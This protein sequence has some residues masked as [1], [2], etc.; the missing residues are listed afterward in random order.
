MNAGSSSVR[1]DEVR[2]GGCYAYSQADRSTSGQR[3]YLELARRVNETSRCDYDNAKTLLFN[4]SAPLPE[5]LKARLRG[6]RIVVRIDGLYFDR[7]GAEFLGRLPKLWKL[8]I[9]TLANLSPTRSFA[10]HLANLLD[11][12][13]KSF[14]RIVLAHHVVYQSE[15]SRASHARYFP[16]KAC[17]VVVNGADYAHPH[18]PP[19][20]GSRETLEVISVHDEWR[21]SKRLGELIHFIIWANETAGVPIRLTLIGYTGVFP[22]SAGCGIAQLVETKPYFRTL[23]RFETYT[24]LVRT[25]LNSSD[26]YITFSYRDACPNVVIEAMAHGLPVVAL[27]SGGIPEIVGDAGIVVPND[28]SA[29]HF[30][31]SRFESDF[32]A[33]KYE[34][35]LDA[36]QRVTG[37]MGDFQVRVRERFTS[38]LSMDAVVAQYFRAM[39]R[40]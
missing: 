20:H 31:A 35:V 16:R 24:G 17:S 40:A 15:F 32:P 39:E 1:I 9:G 21:P 30:T 3:F 34:S 25:A 14:A 18:T 5:I 11:A 26:L 28:D 2:R 12:N 27:A 8:L 29:E 33:V 6:K 37:N 7:L 36:I 10:H 38:Q 4:V 19:Q 13:W 23:P 22:A